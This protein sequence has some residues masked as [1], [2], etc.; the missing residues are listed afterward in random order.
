MTTEIFQLLINS[1]GAALVTGLFLWYQFKTDKTKT[2]REDKL[3]DIL[4]KIST[5]FQKNT[6]A[7]EKNTDVLENIEKKFF[8]ILK[9][10]RTRTKS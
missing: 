6:D 1:S 5:N 3:Q 8:S 10:K 9:K 2:S 7:L 4:I